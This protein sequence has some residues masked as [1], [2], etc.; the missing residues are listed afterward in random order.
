[1]LLKERR[2][3]FPSYYQLVLEYYRYDVVSNA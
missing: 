3:P 1:M 2:H